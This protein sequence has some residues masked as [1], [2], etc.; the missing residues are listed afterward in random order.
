[1]VFPDFLYET[2][3]Y[4]DVVDRLRLPRLETNRRCLNAAFCCD[5][6]ISIKAPPQA[7]W[8]TE[9][10]RPYPTVLQQ[11]DAFVAVREFRFLH[12][13]DDVVHSESE[14]TLIGV[15]FLC[16]MFQSSLF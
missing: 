5:E 1:M 10:Q 6:E 11:M 4:D 2:D 15:F 12:A 13:V 14:I 8:C 3:A 9:V 7:C 16:K